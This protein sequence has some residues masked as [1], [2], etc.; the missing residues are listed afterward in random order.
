[1]RFAAD[2][3]GRPAVVFPMQ[4]AASHLVAAEGRYLDTSTPKSRS[5]GLKAAGVFVASPGAM[6]A[7]GVVVVEGPITALS[8]AACGLPAIALCGHVLRAWLAC[9]LAGRTVFVSLDWDEQGAER[10]G[11]AAFRALAAVG[12]RPYRVALSAGV[13]DWNDHLRAVGLPTMR[14]ELEQAVR[15]TGILADDWRP[16]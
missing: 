4:D 12:A 13:G 15:G 6:G 11:E 1:M 10:H 16:S 5:A 8:V 3:Y 9:C 14:T 2:W 7:D